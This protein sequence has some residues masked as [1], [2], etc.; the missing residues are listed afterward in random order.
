MKW[1]SRDFFKS[2]KKE[3]TLPSVG[4]SCRSRRKP[5]GIGTG[6]VE[7]CCELVAPV[8]WLIFKLLPET[9]AFSSPYLK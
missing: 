5:I 8:M 7:T 2:L 6:L 3:A 9:V 4:G 1:V